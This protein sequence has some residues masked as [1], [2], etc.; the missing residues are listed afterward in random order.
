MGHLA[1]VHNKLPRRQSEHDVRDAA[2]R[3]LRW[4]PILG[5]SR[6]SLAIGTGTGVGG[7]SRTGSRRSLAGVLMM[8][9]GGSRSGSR[10]SL[11]TD[12]RSSSPAGS[13]T[14]SRRKLPRPAPPAPQQQPPG[15]SPD[16]PAALFMSHGELNL[17]DSAAETT[18]TRL[19]LVF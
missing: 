9:G 10:R 19:P 12:S 18:G 14:A 15:P 17:P 1:A 7:G 8:G 3:D 6:R 16:H 4:S 11:G 2:L 5:G 13:R